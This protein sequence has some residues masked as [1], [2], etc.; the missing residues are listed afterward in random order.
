VFIY[1]NAINKNVIG[2]FL[3][4]KNDQGLKAV[5]DVIDKSQIVQ[6]KKLCSRENPVE[7]PDASMREPPRD[8][9]LGTE[10]RPGL[11]CADIKRWGDE[12]AKNG[13]YWIKVQ[14]KGSI[15]VFC[16]MEVDDGGW[17]LFLNYIHNP[18]ANVILRNDVPND[19][20]DN[21]HTNLDI[22]DGRALSELRFMCIEKSKTGNRY[23]HFKSSHQ[24]LISVARN[25]DQTVLDPSSLNS[26]YKPLPPPANMFNMMT[27]D[28]LAPG[29]NITLGRA[30]KGGLTDSP[31]G[32]D[33]LYWTVKG[34]DDE[35]LWECGSNNRI[36]GDR[37]QSEAMV[38]T[39]H[40]IWFR[41]LPASN[42]L[43]KK[44][45]LESQ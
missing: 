30:K 8:P 29:A 7:M 18:G 33:Q 31:F 22:F 19:L 45:Y 41:G 1:Q 37:K 38:E 36:D 2:D 5:K 23:W 44:R 35:D 42:D 9:E 40:S 21:A 16:D 26:K 32:T 34:R 25:G 4:L 15:K 13:N 17:T 3:G 24:S 20:I 11:S 28:P 27:P 14:S 6:C 43:A 12:K 10:K 39:H